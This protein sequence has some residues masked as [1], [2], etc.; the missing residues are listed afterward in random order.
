VIR[1]MQPK[2]RA[3]VASFAKLA[4][5]GG[6]V[7]V[8]LVALLN[9]TIVGYADMAPTFFQQPFVSLLSVHPEQ[10]RQGV[11]SALMQAMETKCL[12]GKLFTSTNQSNSAMQALLAKMEYR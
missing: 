8:A 4:P 11:A 7:A 6:A 9:G 2:E 1:E 3:V 10:H 12:G 5:P